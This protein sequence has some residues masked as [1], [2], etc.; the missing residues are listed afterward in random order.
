MQPW[1]ASH[2]EVHASATEP[3]LTSKQPRAQFN[4]EEDHVH[5]LAAHPPKVA[6]SHL[7]NSL[8]GVS[9]TQLRQD[10]AVTINTAATG[11][12]FWSP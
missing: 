6:I 12:R 8:K 5:L 7:A 9:S 10:L 3:K 2:V 4:T 1:Q 11:D